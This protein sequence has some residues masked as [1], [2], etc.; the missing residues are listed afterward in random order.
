[1]EKLMSLSNVTVIT[2]AKALEIIGDGKRVEGIVLQ[3]QKSHER[4]KVDL[5]G[6]FIQIG[7][8]PNSQF[9]KGVIDMT[10]E[11]EI[12]IDHKCRTSK[13]GIYG[14]GDVTNVAYKQIIV[15][16]GEGAK[17]G[18]SVFEDMMMENL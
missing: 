5:E 8:I 7:L 14:A 17:A 1:V 3:M 2:E 12:K 13:K 9:L 4:R 6:I 11:G 18:L 16:M 10:S 15:A